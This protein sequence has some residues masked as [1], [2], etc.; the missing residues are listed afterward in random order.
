MKR[1]IQII[2]IAGCAW[3]LQSLTVQAQYPVR[4]R[5]NGMPNK[6]A[7]LLEYSGIKTHVIDSAQVQLPGGLITFVLPPSAHPGMYRVVVGPNTYW[8]F[9]FN[10]EPVELQTSY[11][12]V[13]DSLK[14]IRSDE[15]RLLKRYMDHAVILKRK[16]DALQ[17][18]LH[19]YEPG[20]PFYRQ[21]L[22]ELQ[23]ISSADPDQVTRELISKYPGSFTARFL[24]T[25]MNP[26][27]PVE[28]PKDREL[29]YLLD[30]FFDLVDFTDTA[31]LYAPALMGKVRTFF[32]MIPQAYPPDQVEEAMKK[33]LD[34]LMSLTAVN[35]VLFH[36]ILEDIAEWAERSEY[37]T[38][39]AYL[40]EFYLT[41][42][43]CKDPEK[44]K[45]WKDLL[46]SIQKT[47]V[48][49]QA[50]EIILPQPDQKTILLSE[51]SARYKLVV[52]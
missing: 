42:S 37:E 20:D 30:H 8:D 34:R 10:R 13:L 29:K 31:Q 17:Q 19:L 12:S 18:L 11:H 27:V 2:W 52:F 39:F 25:E 45:E 23:K 49:K 36:A 6:R 46:E 21:V 48:G 50:P 51:L 26:P 3:M 1:F 43:D 14:V 24:K 15:N 28:I 9:I 16:N 32:R 38:F 41:E 35:D 5:V 33:G 44:A 40:T 47:K 22:N 7:F 4:I